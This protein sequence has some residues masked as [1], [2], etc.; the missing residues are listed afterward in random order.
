MHI[1]IMKLFL[2][3]FSPEEKNRKTEV[4]PRVKMICVYSVS[5]FPFLVILRGKISKK[6]S[7]QRVTSY[8]LEAFLKGLDIRAR[9]QPYTGVIELNL[10]FLCFY[11]QICV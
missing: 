9:F 2:S 7:F 8:L 5:N 11:F 1:L 3:Q 6:L 4:R 10:L